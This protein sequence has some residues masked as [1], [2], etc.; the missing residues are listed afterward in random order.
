MELNYTVKV[1]QLAN[2]VLDESMQIPSETLSL[3]TFKTEFGV[4]LKSN[5]ENIADYFEESSQLIKNIKLDSNYILGY[6][7]DKTWNYSERGSFEITSEYLKDLLKGLDRYNLEPI[8]NGKFEKNISDQDTV[9]LLSYKEGVFKLESEEKFSISFSDFKVEVINAEEFTNYFLLIYKNNIKYSK[10]TDRLTI[11]TDQF[12]NLPNDFYQILPS[13]KKSSYSLNSSEYFLD[14]SSTNLLELTSNYNVNYDNYVS[15]DFNL[16][17][18]FKISITYSSDDYTPLN[19]IDSFN[20]EYEYIIFEL[21]DEV[22]KPL[23]YLSKNFV[24]SSDKTDYLLL[25]KSHEE[26]KKPFFVVANKAI[27]TIKDPLKDSI[28]DTEILYNRDFEV[29]KNTN[30]SVDGNVIP[31]TKIKI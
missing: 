17:P 27:I 26:Y 18:K 16:P 13:F 29:L 6:D 8:I 3:S 14:V 25:M 11:P 21:E 7:E 5:S 1:Q 22:Y 15:K 12:I 31:L 2:E 23:Y 30:S 20:S 24:I 28:L 4:T 9:N 10:V 19:S